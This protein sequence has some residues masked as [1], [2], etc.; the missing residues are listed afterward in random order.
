[1]S[2]FTHLLHFE[3]EEFGR[4]FSHGALLRR[5]WGFD[6]RSFTSIDFYKMTSISADTSSVIF[7]NNVATRCRMFTC[8]DTLSPIREN[9][10]VVNFW[11]WQI[12]RTGVSIIKDNIKVI[13][14][15]I[16]TSYYKIVLTSVR[17]FAAFQ[18][19]RID[20]FR[21]E[22]FRNHGNLMRIF[23]PISNCDGEYTFLRGLAL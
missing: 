18:I 3:F 12:S 8:Y 10:S 9:D 13:T 15:Q 6:R 11:F 20:L 2:F 21:N 1:M 23:L 4:F 16:I 22:F 19:I 17:F 14:L 5:N 7:I